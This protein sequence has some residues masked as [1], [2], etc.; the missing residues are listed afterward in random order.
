MKYFV[1][2]LENDTNINPF[3]IKSWKDT[4][5]VELNNV[6]GEDPIYFPVTSAA[7]LYDSNFLYGC[8]KVMDKYI[9]TRATEHM[10]HVWKDSCVELFFTPG[11]DISKGYYNLEMNCIGKIY[12]Q[13]QITKGNG[14]K[15]IDLNDL[16]FIKMVTSIEKP[17]LEE[18]TG[19]KEWYLIF[20][21][22]LEIMGK[23]HEGF[24]FP[25]P[26][27][28]W[29]ANF[30]KCADESSNPHWITW[31]KI[32]LPQPQFHRPDYFGELQF[33]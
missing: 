21:Y 10:Q 17:V 3:D 13:H 25:E 7:L 20:A 19:E 1:Q 28:I 30:N 12:M 27:V 31:N 9:V 32:D 18:E 26:G 24:V 22:P 6:M 29:R 8:F 15:L 33:V 14:V 5:F 2:R 11:K 16:N 23:Y 4:E